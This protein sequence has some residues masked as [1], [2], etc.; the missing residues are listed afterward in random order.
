M[1]LDEYIPY[2]YAIFKSNLDLDFVVYPS[3]RDGYAAHTV[4]T[5]YKGFTPKIPFK[6][7]WAGLRDE[8]LQKV[9]GVKTAKFCHKNLFLATAQTKEDA[10]KLIYE[11][12][13]G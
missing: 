11:T 3:N 12:I 7:E 6:K 5:K 2:E 8:E 10:L 1:I 9:S 4:P 13:R